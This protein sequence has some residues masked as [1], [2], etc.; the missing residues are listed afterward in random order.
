[1]ISIMR[2]SEGLGV[3]LSLAAMKTEIAP[4]LTSTGAG[5]S[6]SASFDKYKSAR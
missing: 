5:L 4:R 6:Y 2:L 3:S 1:M